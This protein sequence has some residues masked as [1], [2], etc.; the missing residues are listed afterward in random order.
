MPWSATFIAALGRTAACAYTLRKMSA[1]TVVPGRPTQIV[2]S[3]QASPGLA[4]LSPGA[5]LALSSQSLSIP[6]LDVSQSQ[7]RV[8]VAGIDAG[9]WAVDALPRG[10]ACEVHLRLF[11]AGMGQRI[12][13]GQAR[14]V[15][16]VGPQSLVSGWGPLALV[17]SRPEA[18]VSPG[19]A[20]SGNDSGLF[21]DC[22]EDSARTGTLSAPFTFGSHTTLQ[23][24]AS[25]TMQRET[26]KD[27]A[28]L[29]T[30]SGG[31][32]PYILTYTGVSGNNL[33]G[34]ST[35]AQ[36]NTT[37]SNASAGD[38]VQEVCWIERHP[39][40][41][42]LRILVS[43]GTGTNGIYDTLPEAW[44]LA[45]PEG[46]IDV[47]GFRQTS[48]RLN[49]TIS[50]GSYIVHTVST[51]PQG[52]ALQ[53]LQTELQRY[54]LWLC[55]RQG[56]ISIRPALDYWRHTPPF[57]MQLDATNILAAGLPDR[58]NYDPSNGVE[59][60]YFTV[61]GQLLSDWGAI[62]EAPDTR[63]MIATIAD[64]PIVDG[65]PNVYQ[66]QQ[67]INESIARRAGPWHTRICVVVDVLATLEAAQ[68]C[69]GD[70]V[71]LNH[72][73][74]WDRTTMA[75]SKSVTSTGAILRPAMVTSISCDWSAGTV[76]LRLH[77]LPEA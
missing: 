9:Q 61:R 25:P 36:F 33:T 63:P 66:N 65:Y 6:S 45:V 49:G 14:D 10:A 67:K 69:V 1:F 58:S 37:G 55:T 23:L 71:D 51:T 12:I 43:T 8:A 48:A 13:A 34:V 62:A 21:F 39:V 70:W 35:A 59:A 64:S 11:G 28:V 26:G 68:L 41:M 5:P 40:D 77:I 44:G 47:R 7:W 24:T 22:S 42:A 29:V 16:G 57:V 38:K 15:S 19:T 50:S 20:N 27:G 18:A 56:D 73:G 30:P 60:R 76:S 52:P 4:A 72:A 74:V 31:G 2:S 54:G 53:W 75:R 32:S 46:L 3:D 17:I